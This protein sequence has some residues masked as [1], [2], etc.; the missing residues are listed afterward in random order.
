LNK[1][2]YKIGLLWGGAFAEHAQTKTSHSSVVVR[3]LKL[4]L[5]R[6]SPT[7]YGSYMPLQ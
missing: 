2:S 6:V 1:F 7:I 5:N 3:T 4:G